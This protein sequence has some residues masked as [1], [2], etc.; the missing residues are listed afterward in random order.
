VT[1]A[2]SYVLQA[3]SS[4]G[5]TNLANSDIGNVTSYVATGIGNGTYYIRVRAKN[6]CGDLSA[7]STEATTVV[8]PVTTGGITGF[9]GRGGCQYFDLFDFWTGCK[10]DVTANVTKIVTS[11]NIG[12]LLFWN[13][14]G[15]DGLFHGDLKVTPGS[16]PGNVTIS[17]T[18]GSLFRRYCSNAIP[19]TVELFDGAS[20]TGGVGIPL[21]YKLDSTWTGFG[22]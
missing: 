20:G 1:D 15:G 5:S 22:C 16:A 4:A 8:G 9:F 7:A 6:A 13:T 2:T 18:S 3:G 11:G 21:L 12:V 17:T 10:A 14:G 19:V